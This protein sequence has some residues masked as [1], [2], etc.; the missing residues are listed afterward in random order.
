MTN[1]LYPSIE[2]L[3]YKWQN[4]KFIDVIPNGETTNQLQINISHSGF[5]TNF[6]EINSANHK[7]LIKVV[8]PYQK[9]KWAT[10]WMDACNA[11]SPHAMFPVDGTRCVYGSFSNTETRV[12]FIAHETPEDAIIYVRVG[13]PIELVDKIQCHEITVEPTNK[14]KT[15]KET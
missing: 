10:P 13:I 5:K 12:C 9:A 8:D 2:E 4:F 7:I 6:S 11:T 14:L 15:R 1:H 3:D